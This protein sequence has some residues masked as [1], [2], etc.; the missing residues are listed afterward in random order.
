MS[1]YSLLSQNLRLSTTLPNSGVR[2]SCRNLNVPPIPYA[3]FAMTSP[4]GNG[5]SL[6]KRKIPSE[7]L[8]TDILFFPRLHLCKER[9][10]TRVHPTVLVHCPPAQ[11][12]FRLHEPTSTLSFLK[13]TSIPS[14][15]CNLSMAT[16]VSRMLGESPKSSKQRSLSGSLA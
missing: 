8:L 5:T 13:Q 14:I 12:T 6:S 2:Y 11:A 15:W 4:L 10:R 16:V 9:T 7:M 1:L 3:T